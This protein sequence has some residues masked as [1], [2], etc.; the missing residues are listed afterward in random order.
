MLFAPSHQPTIWRSVAGVFAISV[1]PSAVLNRVTLFYVYNAHI[2]LGNIATTNLA[3]L[4]SKFNLTFR[5][6]KSKYEDGETVV[7]GDGTL[8]RLHTQ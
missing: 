3:F 1:L 2:F 4:S 8:C 7:F 6:C 5:F